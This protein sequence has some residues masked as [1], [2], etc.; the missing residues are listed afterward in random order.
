MLSAKKHTKNEKKLTNQHQI[1]KVQKKKKNQTP[2]HKINKNGQPF[3]KWI[4]TLSDKP[5]VV[6]IF[7]LN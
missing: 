6:S 3:I 7:I 1:N 2:L 5:T 4:S